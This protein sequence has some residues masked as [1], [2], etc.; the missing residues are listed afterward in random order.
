[1]N[2]I[3]TA[4]WSLRGVSWETLKHA[5]GKL[6]T[7][8]VPNRIL[9]D[10]ICTSPTID[11]LNEAEEN[12]FYRLIVH[13]DDFG[14]MDARDSM[15]L[16][17]LY[18][19]RVHQL[20]NDD[21]RQ[22]LIRCAAVGLVEVYEVKGRPYLHMVTWDSH[23]QLR[24]KRPKYPKPEEGQPI[25]YIKEDL[26][27]SA[28]NGNQV[29]ASDVLARARRIQSNPIQSNPIQSGEKNSSQNSLP[30]P[31]GAMKKASRKERGPTEHGQFWESFVDAIGTRP[32]ATPE[33]A[34]WG[35]GIKVIRSAG[36]PLEDV[37]GIVDKYHRRCPNMPCN[38]S[39][40]ASHLSDYWDGPATKP[41]ANE[42]KTE[43]VEEET[44]WNQWKNGK[45]VA[46]PPSAPTPTN[47][48]PL[49]PI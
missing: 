13:C 49:A 10:S 1:M 5:S 25:T 22:R 31:N 36:V 46:Y 37:P 28:S 8:H 24:A 27:S 17:K 7:P 18:P 14:L 3:R 16:A 21:I 12:F 19:L 33:L 4:P 11:E 35:R 15:L 48:Q 23:Q 32:L 40:I 39:A 44:G 41:P 30:A 6:S 2:Y 34:K 43:P 9:K 20:S 47:G 45:Y 29:L 26:Q 42:I 38:P